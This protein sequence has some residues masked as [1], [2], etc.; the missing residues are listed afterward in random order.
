M[1]KL[2]HQHEKSTYYHPVTMMCYR[3]STGGF[4]FFKEW[5]LFKGERWKESGMKRGFIKLEN[6]GG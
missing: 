4:E 1:S 2:T 6:K 5:R 3:K